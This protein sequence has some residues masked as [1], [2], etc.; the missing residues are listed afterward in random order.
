MYVKALQSAGAKILALDPLEEHADATFVEDTCVVLR[1]NAI[2]CR[3]KEK[4]RRGEEEA[5]ARI[6][7]KHRPLHTMESPATIDGGDVLDTGETLFV[8]LSQRTNMEAVQALRPLAG[9][10]VVAVTVKRGLHLKSAVSFLGEDLLVID[11]AS[12]DASAFKKFQ[13]IVVRE[14]ERYAANCL[15]L[16]HTVLMPGGFPGVADPIRERGFRVL[17]LAMSE[18]EKADGGVTCLSL[19]IP[20]VPV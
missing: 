4:S 17:E 1:Q 12:V 15:A 9:K 7:E 10:P 16:R 5:V 20:E 2:L 13:Q 3:P 14:E 8:G 11:P 18:F 6:I 19:I